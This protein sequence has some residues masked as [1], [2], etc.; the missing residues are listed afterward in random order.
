MFAS[1][2][3]DLIKPLFKMYMD[4]LPLRKFATKKYYG[5]DGAFF[6][7]T[8][9]FWGAYMDENYGLDREGK[10]DGLTDNGYIRRYWQG[11]LEMAL[12]MLEYYGMTQNNSFA[13]DT[14]VPFTAEV[15]T[16]FDQH[17][18]RDSNGKIRFEPSQSLETWWVAVNPLPEI[19]GIRT[20]AG[21]MLDLPVAM[22][23]PEQRKCWQRL[24]DDLPPV[25]VREQ[26]GKKVIAPA[27]I[28][29]E[30]KNIENPEL[31]AVFPYRLFGIGKP[32]L[33][34]GVNTFNA[35]EVKGTGGWVQNAIKA[36]CLG[37]SKEAANF[38]GI[39][40][41][42]SHPH[43]RWPATWG[44]NY[45]WVPDQDHGSVAMTALQNMLV[46][47]DDQSVFLLPAWPE[48]WDAEFKLHSRD[49]LVI[50]GRYSSK[51]GLKI[52]GRNVKGAKRI[53]NYMNGAELK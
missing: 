32:D 38:A 27:E 10:P 37:L 43:F 47:S 8:F 21:R 42:A 15:L 24:L 18:K 3:F 51:E 9:Y 50:R 28:Y 2:D 44:P 45:D 17:W 22:T 7:E 39:N 25:P 16:F 48:N 29:S 53:I 6:P 11:G 33:E 30:R 1:G 35:R 13:S 31:Y 5:H 14:L 34:L 4:I 20:V 49:N 26:N 46:Q 12:M 36:A 40:F 52:A 23:T 41:S 19:A